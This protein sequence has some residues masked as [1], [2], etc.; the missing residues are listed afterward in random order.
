MTGKT[1][2]KQSKSR[3]LHVRNLPFSLTE[4]ALKGFFEEKGL[5]VESV[6]IALDKLTGRN[7][8][9][10]FVEMKTSEDAEKAIQVLD[11]SEFQG[12]SLSITAAKPQ[13]IIPVDAKQ[14]RPKARR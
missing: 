12:R 13:K 3:S 7:K 8:G 2:P 5:R 4:S 1:L 10:G 11:G 9:F 14:A 6:R